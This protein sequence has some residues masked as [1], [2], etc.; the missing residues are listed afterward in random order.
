MAIMVGFLGLLLTQG[1]IIVERMQL[2]EQ[3]YFER[4]LGNELGDA[5]QLLSLM[6]SK[7]Q[8]TVEG[9][10]IQKTII[11]KKETGLILGD[12][13]IFCPF[14]AQLDENEFSGHFQLVLRRV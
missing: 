13:T 12:Q 3:H 5:C 14:L 4:A 7:S 10:L 8:L 2:L 9:F 11:Q 1:T 6:A